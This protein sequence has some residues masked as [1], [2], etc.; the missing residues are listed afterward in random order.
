[1]SFSAVI[2]RNF[3]VQSVIIANGA[4]ASAAVSA[5][6]YAMFGLVIPAAFT[7]TT[8]GFQVS[9][10]GT[11]YQTLYDEFNVAVSV[12]VAVSRSYNLPSA[13]AAFSSFKVVSGSAEGA[14]RTLKVTCKT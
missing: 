9:A 1:V 10:D 3:K 8:V 14:A 5:G 7:G 11:T 6:S 4:T 12:T 2:S 13:L